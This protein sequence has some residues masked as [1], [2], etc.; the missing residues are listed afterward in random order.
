MADLDYDVVVIG[1]RIGGST[2]AT[3]LGEA[4]LRVLLIDRASF[5]SPTLSTHYFRGGRAVTVLKHLGVLDSVLALGCPPLACQYGYQDGGSAA[6]VQPAQ[7]P[8]EVEYCLSVRR[9]SLDHI[10]VQRAA[11]VAGVDLLEGSRATDLLWADGRVVGARL[12]TPNGEQTVRTR[13][14]VGADGRRSFVARAVDA[15]IQ[16]SECGHRGVY[17]CYVRGFSGPR[18]E[19]DG[20]EFSRIGDEQAYVFPSE[21]GVTCMALSLNLA[22]F[23]WMRQQPVAR[24][25]E[26]IAHHLGLADRFSAAI[27]EGRLLGCGPETNYVRL[28]FGPGWALVG[29]AG[30]HQDPWSGQGI[31]KATVHATFLAQALQEW[32]GGAAS[33]QDALGRYHQRR[34][35]D[36]LAGYRMTVIRSRDMRQQLAA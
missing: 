21:D 16:E 28:P 11:S 8:G 35:E 13:C 30:M 27:W 24:F 34:D 22:D 18:G 12:A 19:P 6:A 5:P 31:D 2:L 29:D 1:A 7:Q 23:G 20:P 10:L 17:Y 26:R 15:P 33:E 3:L 4:G 9:V 25:R 14:V 36:G 32:L